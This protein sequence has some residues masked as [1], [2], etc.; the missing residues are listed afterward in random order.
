MG[1]WNI[2]RYSDILNSKAKIGLVVI[3]LSAVFTVLVNSIAKPLIDAG[4]FQTIEISPEK[5][6]FNYLI[7]YNEWF[8]L[9]T[10]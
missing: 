2:F 10:K 1:Y 3:I 9:Y 4:G 8:I 7:F 6:N 5:V